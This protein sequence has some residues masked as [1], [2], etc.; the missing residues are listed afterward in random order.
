METRF[1]PERIMVYPWLELREPLTVC[2]VE[3]LPREVS[4][5]RASAK[6]AN[7]EAA[8]S[9]FYSPFIMSMPGE[10]VELSPV[11]PTVVFMDEKT[12]RDRVEIATQV[13]CFSSLVANIE[14]AGLYANATVFDHHVQKLGPDPNVYAR[15]TRRMH[16]NALGG[17]MISNVL[18]VQPAWCGKFVTPNA[19]LMHALEAV[20]LEERAKPIGQAVESLMTATADADNVSADLERAMYARAAERLLHRAGEPIKGRRQRQ[21]ARG[22]AI[23]GPILTAWENPSD[24]RQIMNAWDAFREYRN[25]YWHPDER[26]SP[27][28]AFELQ[29]A[30]H[31]NLV[32]FRMLVAL[33]VATL[34]DLGALDIMSKPA[35]FVP[36]IESWIGAIKENDARDPQEASNLGP[37]LS[38]LLLKQ[39]VLQAMKLTANH[40]ATPELSSVDPNGG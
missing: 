8:T 4:I 32:A 7:I 15:R 22:L 26:T 11:N 18:E 39:T 25:E 17:A 33:I 28:Y 5:A 40:N 2:G 20:I 3:F 23:L 13:L 19:E 24:G 16:G 31:T 12:T 10:P 37:I 27:P 14:R 35:A 29:T 38:S 30:I 6:A 34:V 36:A 21:E 1:E 9:Y